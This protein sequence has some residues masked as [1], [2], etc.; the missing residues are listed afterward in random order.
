MM[1]KQDISKCNVFCRLSFLEKLQKSID[2]KSDRD[3]IRIYY[4]IWLF[5]KKANIGIDSAM[6]EYSEL[7]GEEGQENLFSQLWKSRTEGENLIQF[8]SKFE[9]VDERFLSSVFL[10]V[11]N[12]KLSSRYGVFELNFA[13][14]PQYG[15]LFKDSGKHFRVGEKSSWKEVFKSN[16]VRCNSLI[17]SD[18]YIFQEKETNLYE[19]LDIF[20]PESL[21]VEFQVMIIS[22]KKVHN[23]EETGDKGASEEKNGMENYM[24]QLRQY[25][26]KIRPNLSPKIEFFA[27]TDRQKK[28]FHDRFLLSNYFL[29][30]IGGGFALFNA[31]GECKKETTLHLTCPFFCNES[32][33]ALKSYCSFIESINEVLRNNKSKKENR[34]LKIVEKQ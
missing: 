24:E 13:D 4:D 25:V 8:D 29:G 20:L 6:K 21:D 18:G 19:I 14:I 27:Y 2:N 12:E 34:L 15:F 3:G 7:M 11:E 28:Y 17:I 26:K 23:S 30:E 16:T 9:T 10:T 33:V 1:E 31:Q 22:L 5:L 32:M